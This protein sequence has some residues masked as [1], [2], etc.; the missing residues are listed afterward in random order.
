MWIFGML[1][2]GASCVLE[3]LNTRWN[4]R[5]VSALVLDSCFISFVNRILC[6]AYG[7]PAKQKSTQDLTRY[8]GNKPDAT[9]YPDIV[10][11]TLVAR[12]S[13]SNKPSAH[14]R[15]WMLSLDPKRHNCPKRET[16]AKSM[17]SCIMHRCTAPQGR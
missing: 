10:S 3:I 12:A 13:V 14:V 1:S 17:K 16:L 5:W 4:P 15:V 11:Y 9:M 6:R 2:L 7:R 8:S